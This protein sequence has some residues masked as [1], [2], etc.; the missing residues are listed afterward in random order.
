MSKER[1]EQLAEKWLNGTI[2]EAEKQEYAAW[3]TASQERPLDI[4][5]SFAASREELQERI[6]SNI[7]AGME[8]P[9]KRMRPSYKWAAAAAVLLLLGTGAW[10]WSQRS[11]TS[12]SQTTII[13]DVMPGSDK[14]MLTL[15]GGQRIVLDSG[16]AN[17]AIQNAVVSNGLLSY[18]GN[19]A[20]N[21]TWQ[22]LSTPRGGQ[23]RLVLPDGTGLWLNAESSV[24]FPTKF[25]GKDRRITIT[26]EVY[27]EVRQD[28]QHPFLVT[29]G[30][31]EV[32]VLGTHFNIQAYP[33]E[34]S[35]ATTL[36][37]GSVRVGDMVLQPGEQ[38]RSVDGKKIEKLVN[39]NTSDITAWKDGLFAFSG[40]DLPAMM[41]QVARWYDIDV[42]FEGR[43][44]E[45]SFEGKLERS[46]QLSQLLKVLSDMHIQYKM[47]GKT[48]TIL[49]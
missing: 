15:A 45:F 6:F 10:Y 32:Q 43:V 16:L 39:V 3:Y 12:S 23:Y 30:N 37:E 40:S 28:A 27:L 19:A 42:R 5:A 26:G 34:N 2:S 8:A 29:T 1:Y 48:L 22:T 24:R 35:M 41:R 21:A 49:P 17:T 13:A 4:P 33:D 14:A 46:L 47:E 7:Q 9:V 31:T 38:A 18:A 44:P 11:T 20:E 25:T 36:L